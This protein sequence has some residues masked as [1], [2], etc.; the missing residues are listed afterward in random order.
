[1]RS[2]TTS[3]IRSHEPPAWWIRSLTLILAFGQ[4]GRF[5][6]G[7]RL[8]IVERLI[9]CG[10]HPLWD[11]IDTMIEKHFTDQ[12]LKRFSDY[13][14]LNL[15]PLRMFE[16]L[17]WPNSAGSWSS[18]AFIDV[19]D[20]SNFILIGQSKTLSSGNF[21]ILQGP[22]LCKNDSDGARMCARWLMLQNFWNSLKQN[23][24]PRKET[25]G[26]TLPLVIF[27]YAIC[28]NSRE[29]SSGPLN[30]PE[31]KRLYRSLPVIR[32][33]WFLWNKTVARLYWPTQQALHVLG[34]RDQTPLSTT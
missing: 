27:W 21:D 15:K 2:T 24:M 11:R 6:P 34:Q 5:E 19:C 29:L 22:R 16:L 18:E 9:V 23:T 28:Y 25:S 17:E 10:V 33:P 31:R 13:Q 26:S 30:T 14:G 8:K 32:C 7:W 4:G 1:M 12:S 3:K 20:V